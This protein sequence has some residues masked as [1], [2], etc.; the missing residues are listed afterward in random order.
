MPLE[1]VVQAGR[2]GLASI[3]RPL[4]GERT[5]QAIVNGA[6]TGVLPEKEV[7]T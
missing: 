1:A 5:I 2:G 7:R 4:K 3:K 6:P